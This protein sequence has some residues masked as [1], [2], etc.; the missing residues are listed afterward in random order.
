MKKFLTGALALG[1]M[2]G[3]LLANAAN[4][5]FSHNAGPV[6]NDIF[7]DG[8]NVSLTVSSAQGSITA[9][10]YGLGVNSAF[11]DDGA[12]D[13]YWSGATQ[14]RITFTFSQTVKLD[15]INLGLFESCC[16]PNGLYSLDGGSDLTLSGGSTNVGV[17]VDSFSVATQVRPGGIGN[18]TFRIDNLNV[19]AV[20]LPAAAWL[21]GSALLGL[22][23]ISRRKRA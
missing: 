10:A 22:L 3:S 21:F 11:A 1:A 9:G 23:S 4:I 18:N 20:P 17:A 15:Q 7:G 13:N 19:S 6:Y 2:T 5:D 8:S 16:E 14:E 12:L